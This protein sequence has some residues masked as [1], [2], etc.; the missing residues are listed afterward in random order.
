[1][2]SLKSITHNIVVQWDPFY[3]ATR[4]VSEN[5]RFCILADELCTSG[6]NPGVY[7]ATA[8]P[9]SL[10]STGVQI[11][12][13]INFTVTMGKHLLDDLLAHRTV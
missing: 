2:P 1:M 5:C 9:T 12:P 8:I 3:Q 10:W 7:T 6:M 13:Y 4:G 11:L